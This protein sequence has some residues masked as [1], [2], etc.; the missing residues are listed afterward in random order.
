MVNKTDGGPCLPGAD[1]P[2]WARDKK[3]KSVNN[4][5]SESDT[6]YRGG[7]DKMHTSLLRHLTMKVKGRG[8]MGG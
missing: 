7:R 4:R 2:V 5:I 6:Y 8:W 1:L 3:K